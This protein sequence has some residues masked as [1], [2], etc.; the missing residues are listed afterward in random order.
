MAR[1][2]AEA[3]HRQPLHPPGLAPTGRHHHHLPP[4]GLSGPSGWGR[5]LCGLGGPEAEGAIVQLHTD[6]PFYTRD[7]ENCL[8]WGPLTPG[9][10]QDVS[11]QVQ[12]ESDTC[13]SH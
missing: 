12:A 4:D 1:A 11:T 9:A 2:Q 3:V 6:S 5:D 10:Y 7:Y 13:Q 8:K